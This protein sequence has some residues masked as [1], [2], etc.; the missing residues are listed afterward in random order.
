M[1]KKKIIN[2]FKFKFSRKSLRKVPRQIVDSNI[3]RKL[4]RIINIANGKINITYQAAL[5]ELNE[6][7]KMTMQAKVSDQYALGAFK[8]IIDNRFRAKADA[9]VTL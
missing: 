3:Y 8:S 5:Q 7:K 1:N 6:F 4:I 9:G 2:K